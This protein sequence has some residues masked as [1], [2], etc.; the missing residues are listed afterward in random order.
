M[1]FP[2]YQQ[3]YSG[4]EGALY[5]PDPSGRRFLILTGRAEGHTGTDRISVVVNWFSELRQRF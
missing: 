4:D 5:S 2:A 1:V 3:L